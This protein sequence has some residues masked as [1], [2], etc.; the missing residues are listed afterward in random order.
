ML[1][2]KASRQTQLNACLK[3]FSSQRSN[4]QSK[5]VSVSERTNVLGKV[6]NGRYQIMRA[7]GAGGFSQ[8]YLAK[9]IY[10]PSNPTCVVK[11]FKPAS[12]DPSFLQTAQHLYL[13]QT[14]AEILNSLSQH[15]QIPQ[16]LAYFEEE[17]NFYLV[18]QY[19][20]GEPLSAEMPPGY[21]WS[22][23]QVIQLLQEVLELLVFI[24]SHGVIHRDIKP[25][26]LI[27]QKQDNKLVLINFGTIKQIR[28]QTVTPQGH[29]SATTPIGTQG[30]MAAE[31]AQGNPRP[32]SDLYALGII[33]V[34]ALMGIEPTQF[35]LDPDTAEICWQQQ[36]KVSSDLASFISKLVSYH[37][38]DRYQLATEALE[39]LQPLTKIQLPHQFISPSPFQAK[40][41]PHQPIT[42]SLLSTRGHKL[43]S[44]SQGEDP[45]QQLSTP[46]I[47]LSQ[48][49]SFK[50]SQEA[51]FSVNPSEQTIDAKNRSW[52]WAEIGTG[53]ASAVA[54][55]AGISFLP[56]SKVVTQQNNPNPQSSAQKKE[57]SQTIKTKS[58]TPES[59]PRL[60]KEPKSPREYNP[61]EE[62]SQTT[63]VRP[64]TPRFA[65]LPVSRASKA[66]ENFSS[67]PAEAPL[68][69]AT[70]NP[71][72]QRHQLTKTSANSPAEK[73]KVIAAI[74]KLSAHQA[75]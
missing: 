5:L 10:R 33:S 55:S 8:T 35:Q 23:S 15:K 50:Q 66:A 75:S 29:R 48:V 26:N 11:H 45:S 6:L 17:Q 14:E 37:F 19:V 52:I 43:G 69:A 53:L 40:P 3:A 31:Q 74:A 62:S 21:C 12:S 2:T 7:L 39:A 58:S 34:Q 25:D 41:S 20:D 27:R 42:S 54:L 57:T 1:T 28:T 47:S 13:F 65:P 38:K 36:V 70:A 56:D 51:V 46:S 60:Q 32:N 4:Q 73:L 44:F 9:D 68:I 61:P 16:L 72:A 49:L 59:S 63:Y 71:L 67:L 30:Y 22:E 18:Q 64:S 24:H